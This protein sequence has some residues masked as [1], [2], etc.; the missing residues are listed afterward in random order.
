MSSSL[1]LMW[2]EGNKRTEEWGGKKK[3][4]FYGSGLP[5]EKAVPSCRGGPAM[6]NVPIN[7]KCAL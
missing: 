6:L 7:I 5:A 1:P 3:K 4:K 2:T